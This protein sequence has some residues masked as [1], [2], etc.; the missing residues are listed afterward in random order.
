[1][2]L[3]MADARSLTPFEYQ[4][5]TVGWNRAHEQED[6]LEPPTPE[7]IARRTEALKAKGYKVLH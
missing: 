3:T 4:A 1:M 7:Q 2:G 6:E 5:L